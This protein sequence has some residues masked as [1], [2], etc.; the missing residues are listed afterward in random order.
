MTEDEQA[1]RAR[2]AREIREAEVEDFESYRQHGLRW[3]VDALQSLTDHQWADE[4]GFRIRR[5][6]RQKNPLAPQRKPGRKPIGKRAM[7]GAE[8]KAR[9]DA[10]KRMQ[11]GPSTDRQHFKTGPR[12]DRQHSKTGPR[13][14]LRSEEISLCPKGSISLEHPDARR[15]I[16]SPSTV[17]GHGVASI[18]GFKS[19]SGADRK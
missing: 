7:T 3:Y 4:A 15:G 14:G 11:K 5:P 19:L 9:H 16:P 10:K 6:T 1:R 2:F 17:G 8:R 12:T 13:T 18:N